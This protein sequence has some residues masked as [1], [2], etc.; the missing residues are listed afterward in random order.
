MYIVEPEAKMFNEIKSAEIDFHSEPWPLIDR[1][2]KHLVMKMLT[3]NPKERI[4]A[5]EVLRKFLYFSFLDCSRANTNI[6]FLF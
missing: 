1:K 5:A 3:R 4:S 2:A 6:S